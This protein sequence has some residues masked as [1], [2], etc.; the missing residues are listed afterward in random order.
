MRVMPQAIIRLNGRLSEN[1]ANSIPVSFEGEWVRVETLLSRLVDN[2]PQNTVAFYAINGT[3]VGAAH[4]IY[5]GDVIDV[6]PHVSG[7]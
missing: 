1:S 6:Y 4:L 2:L 7:G 5:D 3:R